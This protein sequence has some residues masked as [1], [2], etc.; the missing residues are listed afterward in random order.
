MQ[1]VRGRPKAGAPSLKQVKA[2]IEK[3]SKE[4]F[5]KREENKEAGDALSDW[6][7]AEK[8]VKAKHHLS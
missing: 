6:L 5:Q 8:Q 3:R 2:E 4:I 1:K 7:K